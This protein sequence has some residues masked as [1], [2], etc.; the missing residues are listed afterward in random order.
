M[1]GDRG[2][3]TAISIYYGA[4]K[5]LISCLTPSLSNSRAGTRNLTG[6]RSG[7]CSGLYIRHKGVKIEQD[8]GNRMTANSILE[9]DDVWDF[10]LS[11]NVT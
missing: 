2:A 7:S 10:A 11:E 3:L 6:S 8:C 9:P 5:Q 1:T 4:I